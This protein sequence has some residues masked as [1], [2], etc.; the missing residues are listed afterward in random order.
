MSRTASLLVLKAQLFALFVAAAVPSPLL[1]PF[2]QE[3]GFGPAMVT[4]IFATYAVALLVA[5]LTAGGLSDHVG[6]R[7][8][9]IGTLT[10]EAAGM[11]VFWSAQ[12]VEWLIVGRAVQGVATGIALGAL[13]A[14]I[15]EAAPEDSRIG[16][17]IN[18]FAP[19]SGLAVGG[20]ATG[21]LI[22]RV[23]DPVPVAFASLTALFAIFGVVSIWLPE[24]GPMRPGALRSLVPRVSV[25]APARRT[26]AAVVPG[27]AALWAT[28]GLYLSLVPLAM[29]DVFGIHVALAGGLAIGV[30]NA[31][32]AVA[33]LLLRRCHPS[34]TTVVGSAALLL[35]AALIATSIL[36]TSALLFYG[37]TVVAGTGFG[38]VFSAGPRQ[39]MEFVPGDRRAATFASIYVVSYVAFSAP[40]L[41]AGVL[42][43][44]SGMRDVLLGYSV[45]VL[46]AAAVSLIAT[47]AERTR[48]ADE[49]GPMRL[50]S[51]RFGAAD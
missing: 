17:L 19:L 28:G 7:P 23:A 30:L 26:F 41:V 3:F 38:L 46:L 22:Q 43:R 24:T 11:A 51:A 12:G 47:M 13:N 16:A 48:T 10:L 15:L 9:L 4:V 35:G 1:V 33:P 39:V 21:W 40:A 50:S 49:P 34:V 2:R 45:V 31:S 8:V 6:R 32:G 36:L 25:P 14:A 5:L 27:I 20:V 44:A 18:G 37:A 29:R 42:V